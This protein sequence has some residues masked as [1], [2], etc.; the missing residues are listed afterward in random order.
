[1]FGLLLC[2]NSEKVQYLNGNGLVFYSAIFK[3]IRLNWDFRRVSLKNLEKSN[4]E[5]EIVWDSETQL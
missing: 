5:L 4:R 1:M 3:T 2:L